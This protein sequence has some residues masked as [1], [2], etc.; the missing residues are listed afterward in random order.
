MAPGCVRLF[1]CGP[2]KFLMYYC[3]KT[4][5]GSV[6]L[7]AYIYISGDKLRAAKLLASVPVASP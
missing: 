2:Q 5:C 6:I 7:L 4:S 3:Y 1:V